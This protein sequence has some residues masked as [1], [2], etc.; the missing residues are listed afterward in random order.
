MKSNKFPPT[1]W[2]GQFLHL[3]LVSIL[4]IFSWLIWRYLGR[5]LTAVFWAAIAFPIA[6]QLF[7]WLAW[8]FELQSSLTSKYIGFRIYL[9]IFF[10]LFSG[11]LLSV[12]ILAWLDSNSLKLPNQP[13]I[14]IA[15]TF[16]I[17]G[18][19][20]MYSVKK[21]F[22]M[23]RAAGVDHFDQAYRSMPLVKKGIFRLTDNAMY[24]YAF[25]LFWAIAIGFNSASALVVAAFSHIYIWVHFYC[26]EK[27][28]MNFI[29]RADQ[30]DNLQ[31]HSK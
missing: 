22:G 26:T 21:Y 25:L 4:L 17:I 13:R 7:V 15:S 1:I 9:V 16:M 12:F 2:H 3:L 19:Y 31:V 30:D 28:D 23:S 14:F 29:Y 11:R 27:P 8:R 6:H 24:F 10:L 18:V 5:P 20:A